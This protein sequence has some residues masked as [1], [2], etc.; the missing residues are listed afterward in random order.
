MNKF[1]TATTVLATYSLCQRIR[2]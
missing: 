1:F 2:L